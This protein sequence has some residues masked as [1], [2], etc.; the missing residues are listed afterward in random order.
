M[1]TFIKGRGAERDESATRVRGIT[2]IAWALQI[3]SAGMFLFAGFL[4]LTGDPAM[5]QT[6]G[7]IGL[8]QWF[9]FFTGGLEI[10]AAVLLLIPAWSFYGAMALAMTMVGAVITHLFIVGGNP[11][12]AIVL[13]ATTMIVAWIRENDR[14]ISTDTVRS[15]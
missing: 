10:A 6:F 15:L 12:P 3:L 1:T 8:G 11:A 2:A 9:R 4:K 13:L 14:Y 7:V 5:V